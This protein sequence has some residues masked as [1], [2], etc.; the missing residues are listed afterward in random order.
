MST[1]VH[2][3]ALV[4]ASAQLGEGVEIGAFAIVGPNCV[5]GDGSIVSA[6]ASL[7]RNDSPSTNGIVK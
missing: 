3:T 1:T 7:E 5:I 6:R 4:D 2:P